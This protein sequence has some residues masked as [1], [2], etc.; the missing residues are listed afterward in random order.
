[1]QCKAE[2]QRSSIFFAPGFNQGISG[3]RKNIA[4]PEEMFEKQAM[5][6][7]EHEM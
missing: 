5:H 1:M 3:G 6:A 2:L 4:L 7:P